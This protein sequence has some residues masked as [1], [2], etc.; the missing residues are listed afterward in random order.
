MTSAARKVTAIPVRLAT[1][2]WQRIIDLVAPTNKA[3]RTELASVT[4]VAASLITREAMKSSPIIVAGDGPRLRIYCVYGE[5]AVAGDQ[6]N[7]AA[8]AA[9]PAEKGE[10]TMSLPCSAD[11]LDWVRASLKKRSSRVT[12]RDLAVTTLVEADAESEG[13]SATINV[14]SFLRL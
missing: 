2:T 5:D 13:S 4:G 10:W 3:A 11:D 1:D 14:E 7:E 8:L 6:A 9:S 12:A